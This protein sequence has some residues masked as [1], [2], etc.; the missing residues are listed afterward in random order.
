MPKEKQAILDHLAWASS[1]VA[2]QVIELAPHHEEH[3]RISAIIETLALIAF[4][5]GWNVG[6][7]DQDQDG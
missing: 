4:E 1:R 6:Y 3:E 7:K 2:D 5:M